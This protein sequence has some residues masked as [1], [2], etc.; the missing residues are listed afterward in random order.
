MTDN[1]EAAP[2]RLVESTGRTA[3]EMS[4]SYCFWAKQRRL[5][6]CLVLLSLVIACEKQDE[7]GKVMLLPGMLEQT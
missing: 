4:V 2:L 3:F 6:A 1:E 7:T 5:A